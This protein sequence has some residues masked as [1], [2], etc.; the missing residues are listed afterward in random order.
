M[1]DIPLKE[2]RNTRNDARAVLYELGDGWGHWTH[3]IRSF[4]DD[5]K[6]YQR[7]GKETCHGW[8]NFDSFDKA[9]KAWEEI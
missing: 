6:A 7:H 3:Q 4:V 9:M 1:R 8:V 5:G 2:K